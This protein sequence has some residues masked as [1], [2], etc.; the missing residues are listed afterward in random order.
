LAV[1][2]CDRRSASV[3][4]SAVR[5][6]N[7]ING[8]SFRVCQLM[9][10]SWRPEGCVAIGTLPSKGTG[11]LSINE[12]A[13][14]QGRHTGCILNEKTESEKQIARWQVCD[15]MVRVGCAQMQTI[16]KDMSS[17][18]K[19]RLVAR[20]F[21][22]PVFAAIA[23]S[24]D[25]RTAL[26]FLL[27]AGVVR[28][29][30]NAT[31]GSLFESGWELL[32]FGYRNEYV[33][34][35]E[36]AN[37]VVFGR[38]SPRTTGVEIELPVGRSIVDVATFNGTSTAYE[39]KTEFD[40]PRRMMTQTRD[41]LKA[42]DR[43]FVVAHPSSALQFALQVDEHVGVLA[44]DS[45]G[46]LSMVKPAISNRCNVSVS[47]VFRCLRREEYVSIAE[48]IT[49]KRMDHPNGLISKR[50]EECFSTLSP[51]VAHEFFLEAMRRRK[52]DASTVSFV[53]Q[54]P[55]SLRTLGYATPLS[56]RRRSVALHSMNQ[57]IRLALAT[58]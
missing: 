58:N 41:Y 55:P 48:H 2:A 25:W 21:T 37:R 8:F 20:M 14:D 54:L 23:Q 34:K 36:I 32:R 33:Y 9:R 22:R 35:S 29:S 17:I 39:I 24:G 46:S 15:P 1:N 11:I 16:P 51:A 18:D 47:T 45:R 31:L 26:A 30:Q 19:H 7:T 40:T 3:M 57:K 10:R 12:G 4:S 42:F 44:L 56:A 50:C 38:H 13:G 53:S 43:V 28:N 52:T 27:R 49:G 6:V 5:N